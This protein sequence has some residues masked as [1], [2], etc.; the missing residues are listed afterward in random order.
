[1][2][3]ILFA[4]SEAVPFI[5]TG[6]LADVV[7]SL[8]KY[9]DKEKYDVRV[10]VPKYLCIRPELREQM[11][12]VDKF[13]VKMNWRT[14]YVGI[15]EM[16]YDGV[17]YYF[18]DNEYYFAGPAPYGEMYQDSE[19]FAYFSRAVLEALPVIGFQPD[20]IHWLDCQRGLIRV[21]LKAE[22]SNQ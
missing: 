18:L 22:Y 4:A 16:E 21:H 17:K 2:K 9:F 3:K 11:K 12:F 13:Y 6:G 5:K 8:P 15:D 14:Q 7:G 20:V 10:M 19:K 1:M